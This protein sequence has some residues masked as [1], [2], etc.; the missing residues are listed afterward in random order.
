MSLT[1]L[2][3]IAAAAALLAT[4]CSSTP[5]ST[6]PPASTAPAAA[7][8][9]TSAAP[10]PSA[11][12][13][14]TAAAAA[15]LSGNWSGRY[16]GAY[17]GTFRLHWKQTGTR[18]SG[19]IKISAPANTLGLHGTVVNGAIR[20]GTVGSAAITY[21]GTVSGRSMSGTYQVAGGGSSTGGPWSASEVS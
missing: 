15:G 17:Q 14:A 10:A 5:K 1:R 9:A 21:S 6:A 13:P 8:P 18:L 16:S 7:A 12:A 3:L 11:Q 4:G 20:F 19:T 2:A